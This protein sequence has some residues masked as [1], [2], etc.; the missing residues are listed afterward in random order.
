M[1]EWQK[2][3]DK[4]G[5]FRKETKTLGINV[6][7]LMRLIYSGAF[8]EMLDDELKAKPPQIRY[9]EMVDQV[10]SVMKSKASLPKATSKELVG[11]NKIDGIGNLMLWRF[12]T[13]P[14]VRYDVSDFCKGFL[15]SQ[16]FERPVM[17]EG[18]VTW[19]KPAKNGNKT[20]IDIRY[21]WAELFQKT[22]VLEAYQKDRLLGS[23]CI[24]VKAEKKMFQSTKE[25]LVVTL[26]NGHEYI[27]GVRMWPNESGKL[28]PLI[29]NQIKPYNLGLAIIR[30]KPW[31]DRP[32]GTLLSWTGVGT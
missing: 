12:S 18:D 16:G 30:P 25:S 11:I 32:G 31:N 13:N 14:F 20:R 4:L 29:I 19:M 24:V 1:S 15:K 5:R 17:P 2:F 9:K 26:F 3:V 22:R 28:N 21:S 6:P 27:E 10:V 8:D 23:M 7:A